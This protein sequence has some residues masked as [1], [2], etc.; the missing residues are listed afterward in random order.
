MTSVHD[1]RGCEHIILKYSGDGAFDALEAALPNALSSVDAKERVRYLTTLA[2]TALERGDA[3]RA[4]PLCRPV[5]E[6]P[7]LTSDALL[8]VE[9]LSE[10]CEDTELMRRVLELHVKRAPNPTARARALERLGDFFDAWQ[11]DSRRA[12]KSWRA[13]ALQFSNEAGEIDDSR[14]LYERVLSTAPSDTLSA[15][16]LVELC[17][18]A[19]DWLGAA[20]AFDSL[21]RSEPDADAVADLLLLL[22]P[23][24]VTPEAAEHFVALVDA[25]RWQFGKMPDAYARRLSESTARV[26]GS[27]GRFDKAAEA[28]KALLETYAADG[29]AR[30][31]ETLIDAG[32]DLEWRHQQWAWLYEW[33]VGR[34]RDPSALL[35]E[36]AERE[37]GEFGDVAAATRVY[38][39]VTKKDPS[40]VKA[41]LGLF[42]LE[43]AAGNV[44][45]T[46]QALEQLKKLGSTEHPAAE[47]ALAKALIE[48]LGAP[49]RA[50]PLL[51]TR[52]ERNAGDA[53]AR[54]LMIA[55]A[56][57]RGPAQAAAC[58]ALTRTVGSPAERLALAKQLLEGSLASE[59]AE[60]LGQG[61][62]PLLEQNPDLA[63]DATEL[64][65]RVL[66]LAPHARWALDRVKFVLTSEQ[67]WP[68]LFKLYERAAQSTNDP[69]VRAD[70]LD[71]A[72]LVARDIAQDDERAQAFWEECL[73]LRPTDA[74]IDAALAR[75]YERRKVRPKLVAHLQR[76]LAQA[77]S[78]ERMSLYEKIAGLHLQEF[79]A[80]AALPAIRE[81]L[82]A[83]PEGPRGFELLEQLLALGSGR[84]EL[85]S[86]DTQ[87]RALR[88]AAEVLTN[89]YAG[90]EA[91]LELER[92]LRVELAWPLERAERCERLRT[93]AELQERTGNP[94]A[95]FDTRTELLRLEPSSERARSELSRLATATGAQRKLAELL[96]ELA[97]GAISRGLAAMLL[98]AAAQIYL[99]ELQD[100]A[101]AARTYT[102][103]LRDAPEQSVKLEAAR[104]L[105]RLHGE[106]AQARERCAVL[107]TLAGLESD[108]AARRRAL[109][110]AAELALNE[111]AEAGRAVSHLRRLV[112]EHDDPG[113][114]A[115]LLTALRAAGDP[116]ELAQALVARSQLELPGARADLI[117]AARIH[118]QQLNDAKGARRL[119]VLVGERFGHDDESL[120]ALAALLEQQRDFIEL[121][122][123]LAN[124]AEKSDRPAPL[125][126]RLARVLE[127]EL[128]ERGAA[129]EAHIKAGNLDVA[130]ALVDADPK[131]LP[132]DG[133]LALSLAR[134]LDEAGQSAKAVHVLESTLTQQGD[135]PSR[136]AAATH[137]EIG[138]LLHK[139][140]ETQAALKRLEL[141]A[142]L[143]PGSA[144]IL[145]EL[146]TL[147][148]E[149]GEFTR[150]EQSLRALLLALR[151]GTERVALT[152]AEIYLD[153]S[154]VLSRQGRDE[155][156]ENLV[157]SAFDEAL[158]SRLEAFGLEAGL[159]RRGKTELL[160]RAIR[161]RVRQEHAPFE[162]ARALLDLFEIASDASG[163]L[164]LR[165]TL[166]ESA[167]AACKELAAGTASDEERE[168]ARRL[169]LLCRDAREPERA[170]ELFR[171]SLELTPQ[172]QRGAL[173]REFVDLLV[174]LPE[175]HAEALERLY[176]L[177]ELGDAD[178]ETTQLFARLLEERGEIARAIER[179]NAKLSDAKTTGD[180][181]RAQHLRLTL[182][183]LFERC[184]RSQEAL[185]V[186]RMAALRPRRRSEALNAVLRVLKAVSGGAGDVADVLEQVLMLPETTPDP[187]QVED[188]VEL[189]RT[190]GDLGA[191][192]R[193]LKI[194]TKLFPARSDFSSELLALCSARGDYATCIAVLEG[195]AEATPDNAGLRLDLSRYQ[196]RA[197]R[198][199]AALATL[200]ALQGTLPSSILHQ[201]LFQTLKASGQHREA[202]LEMEQ[203]ARLDTKLVPELLD[204]IEASPLESVDE[205]FTLL[206]A[207]LCVERR[208]HERA[209]NHL[210]DALSDWSP[211]VSLQRYAAK[212]AS[213]HGDA[214]KAVGWLQSAL[215]SAAA[216]EQIELAR[217]FYE[218]CAKAGRKG[219]AAQEL[220][221]LCARNPEAKKALWNEL[222]AVLS[223][224]EQYASHAELLLERAAEQKPAEREKL[225]LEAARLFERAGAHQ[226]TLETA[227]E[228]IGLG[229]GN[230][231]LEGNLLEARAL[232][233]LGRSDEALASLD[234]LIA[235]GARQKSRLKP[236]HRLLGELYLARDELC[237]ALP[238]LV[239]AHQLDRGD[240]ELAYLLGVTALDLDDYETAASALRVVIAAH[241][242]KTA[243]GKTL[244]AAQLS[245]TYFYLAEFEHQ[246]GHATQAKRMVQ[247]AL[248]LDPEFSAARQLLLELS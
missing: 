18:T 38:Q 95:A 180:A 61:L 203:A 244:S 217:E 122:R 199:D 183:A 149:L 82:R 242:R 41:W 143:K 141:A 67:R 245:R 49:E 13:A 45:G 53:A 125:Y 85:W 197:G 17:A 15:T 211:S 151:G 65:L 129:L 228:L 1:A 31:F 69:G 21:I 160:Q 176:A 76:K 60:E 136:G 109:E 196:R 75:L 2:E 207:E 198:P 247:R 164:E 68:E 12:T 66:E 222:C 123:L 205:R 36:W 86:Q 116:L 27:A 74:R 11:H 96:S 110:T 157:T 4:I 118:E 227:Q 169:A 236:A 194:G 154:D 201:E 52:L 187:E 51:T 48:T 5:L 139:T 223:E 101:S 214:D 240:I 106:L 152:R 117:E 204:A 70:W 126:S 153:L 115:K 172:E 83:A 145:A 233:A 216:E 132:E 168:L 134:A 112:A 163:D 147:A 64:W 213:T 43:L 130:L 42:Q 200:R 9:R 100:R 224:T 220:Q 111:L 171:L 144:E 195:A 50:L 128:G 62:V 219:E 202:L 88:Q 193:A 231:Q 90:L 3:R 186:F 188:L 191:R 248:E 119:W 177:V 30:E 210:T 89:R 56:K 107:E 148:V 170:V 218:V 24:A 25:A 22:E 57:E 40:S 63:G 79:D 35:L 94:A 73:L 102:K 161:A 59:L 140:G 78:D 8:A 178:E 133:I 124:A 175:G 162:R 20:E 173:E 54:E 174:A 26:L 103:I 39:R 167:S 32:P 165:S 232:L 241:E 192:E 58:H 225:L 179:I 99:G 29:H 135:K 71:E 229:H 92:V 113:L 77:D 127:S 243:V 235:G 226:R 158:Q 237:E 221:R 234:G 108:A 84:P 209:L 238:E 120:Q 104:A 46:L 98:G 6:A 137:L 97:S 14:R 121:A 37:A 55:L 47:L 72:A 23:Q 138:R 16:R 146:S 44:D 150:A 239:Q 7:E 91:S 93:L 34:Q 182:G 208:E 215:G 246:K 185:Q 156:A 114:Q 142:K 28:Y 87:Q 166:I 181:A 230:E 206:F 131:L 80:A 189:R 10:A 81:V 184:G 105:D 19:G 159:R 33:R 190:Q 212:L 155:D